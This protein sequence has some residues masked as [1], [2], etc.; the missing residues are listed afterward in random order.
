VLAV[1]L[2]VGFVLKLVGQR[3]D[4]R[5]GAAGFGQGFFQGASMP[6]ALPTLLTGVDVTIYA[7]KNN[8]VPY[9]IGYILG[10]TG[11]GAFFFGTVYGQMGVRR[12]RA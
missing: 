1:A 2:S 5:E 3:L 7:A 12:R 10:I 6:L 9:K 8:G 4:R 11:C